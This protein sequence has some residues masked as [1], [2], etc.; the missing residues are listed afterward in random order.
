MGCCSSDANVYIPHDLL[1]DSFPTEICEF[2][3]KRLG[4][5]KPYF[6]VCQ[7]S[8]YNKYRHWLL[9]R[10]QSHSEWRQI[11]IENFDWDKRNP[12]KN[13]R[14]KGKIFWDAIYGRP[15]L[16]N[17]VANTGVPFIYGFY[18]NYQ[19]YTDDFY[20]AHGQWIG[21]LC[22]IYERINWAF[23]SSVVLSPFGE[24]KSWGPLEL[25]VYANG[26]ALKVQSENPDS[27]MDFYEDNFVDRVE[28]Q[29]VNPQ[30]TILDQWFVLGETGSDRDGAVQWDSQYFSCQSKGSWSDF[31]EILVL[32]KEESEPSLSLLVAFL[33]AFE[34]SPQG[35]KD[36]CCWAEQVVV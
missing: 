8:T 23:H 10:K 18:D 21:D 19:P 6:V 16:Q 35:I 24:R 30:G 25:K 5:C 32:S 31:D 12:D 1:P 36:A 4:Y 15:T 7:G 26:V 14:K 29:L 13:L 2:S 11:E 27:G 22:K 34:F 20:I 17:Q 3:I 28:Y 9:L 33:C